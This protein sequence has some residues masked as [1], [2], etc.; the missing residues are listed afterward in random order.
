MASVIVVVFDGLQPKQV[1][2]QLMPNLADFASEGVAFTKH[3]P[4]FPTVTRTG[5][6]SIVT[7][8]YPG[9]HGLAGNTFVARDFD[10]ERAIDA[11]MP[12]LSEVVRKTGRLLLVPAL[13]EILANHNQ[14]YDVVSVGTT[15]N[16]YVNNVTAEASGGVIIHPDFC[17]PANL[18]QKIVQQ[19][20]GWPEKAMPNGPRMNKAVQILTE[21]IVA[22]RHPAVSLIWFSEPDS[23]QHASGVGSQS[24]E[25]ALAAADAAFGLL[26]E[27]LKKQGQTTTTN[28]LVTSDHGYSTIRESVDVKSAIQ[29]SSLGTEIADG[30]IIVVPIGGSVLFYVRDK[31]VLIAEKLAVWLM[32]QSW[33]GPLLASQAVSEIAGTIPASVVGNE[34]ERV[35][36]LIMSFTWD[37]TVNDKGFTGFSYSS[38]GSAGQGQHGSMSPNELNNVLFAQGPNFKHNCSIDTPT[39]NID[40]TPTILHILGVPGSENM[41]GR[42]LYEGL[43]GE[44]TPDHQSIHTEVIKAERT[45]EAGVFRQEISVTHVNSS[46]YIDSGK[47]TLDSTGV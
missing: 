29:N 27:W 4:V 13:G 46:Y 11:M 7:G 35:P 40:I 39:G 36:D 18:S 8:C 41:D 6:A 3:H 45:I 38:S 1:T 33:C 12:E 47:A 42:V 15:G 17:L 43:H 10:P 21:Y 5:V 31:N 19:F 28:I 2:A 25:R 23:S 22:E 16:A 32:S 26:L 30:A 24:S 20:G 37:S 9:R 34:G 14:E 44:D